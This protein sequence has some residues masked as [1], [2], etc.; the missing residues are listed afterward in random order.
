MAIKSGTPL[1]WLVDIHPQCKLISTNPPQVK[2]HISKFLYLKLKLSISREILGKPKGNLGPPP[3]CAT[4]PTP[5]L[6]FAPRAEAPKRA[7]PGPR[8]GSAP[9]AARGGA[10][11]GRAPPWP[12][13]ARTSRTGARLDAVSGEKG[14]EWA[15]FWRLKVSFKGVGLKETTRKAIVCVF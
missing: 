14:R 6:V 5:P 10:A 8:P 11:G 13:P 3:L 2:I 15:R 1:V 7:P 9:P 12:P 4:N